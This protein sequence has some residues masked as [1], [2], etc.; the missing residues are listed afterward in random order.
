[1][2]SVDYGALNGQL[3]YHY[4]ESRGDYPYR[5]Q[6]PDGQTREEDRINAD[7]LSRHLTGRFQAC[8]R[9][10]RLAI[11]WGLERTQRGLPGKINCW[12]AYARADRTRDRLGATYQYDRQK[13][14]LSLSLQYARTENEN[15]NLW[16]D[17]ADLRYRRSPRYHYLNRLSTIDFD[18]RIH[19]RSRW[20]MEGDLGFQCRWLH[21]RDEDLYLQQ[22][23]IGSAR[24]HS[25]G[26]FLSQE[27][28]WPL[29]W[30]SSQVN[31]HPSLRYDHAVLDSD[32][33][34]RTQ[35]HWSPSLGLI[36]SIGEEWQG[37]LRGHL[38]R[39]FRLPTF[40]DLFYE[41]IKI[42]GKPDLLP[43]RS[44]HK[45]LSLGGVLLW[46]GRFEAEATTFDDRIDDLIVWRMGDFETFSPFNTDAHIQGQDYSVKWCSWGSFV[47]VG[48]SYS[49]LRAVNKSGSRTTHNKL[50]PFRPRRSGRTDVNVRIEP[51]MIGLHYR[52]VGERF[53]TESNTVRMPPY[54]ILDGDISL[55]VRL[56]AID[57]ELRG[58]CFNLTDEVY[59]VLEDTPLPPR[60]W[61]LGL[62]L[63]KTF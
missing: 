18:S 6:M 44:F 17:D 9:S 60:E 45:E 11:N 26:V 47:T 21:Y 31:L 12:T 29:G 36:C 19:L 57:T 23:P 13:A 48:M 32:T 30:L 53:V 40:A 58:A 15:T 3:L 43:E 8:R 51:F 56:F 16:P 4:Q 22:E 25:L 41:E 7:L 24:D 50:L 33:R 55:K 35:D 61:R 5:Y 52:S 38:T 42:Q 54:W 1:M 2:W 59:Q 20:W 46:W 37:Y 49:V 34:E 27:W 10:H 63:E 39:A 28:R 62:S 14:Q